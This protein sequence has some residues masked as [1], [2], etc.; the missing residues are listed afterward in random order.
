MPRS[1]ILL[2]EDDVT[3]A[4]VVCRYLEHDGHDVDHV[5]DGP[6]ALNRALSSSPDLVVLD[7][8]MPGMDG[9]E[10]CR[11][12]RRSVTTP[13]ILLTALGA[14]SERVAGLEV[15]AD[16]YVTKPFSPRELSLRVQAVLRR[17]H[18]LA[19]TRQ[20]G[21]LH[22]GDLTLDLGAR[23]AILG[24]GE[25]LLTSRE[26]DLL[27]FF[28]TN[29]NQVFSRKDLLASVWGWTVGDESTVTV[30]V[31]RLRGKLEDDAA[32]PR[33]VLTVWGSGYRYRPA[34]PT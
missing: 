3:I 28:L 21:V 13:V 16:D 1:K 22:D 25:L 32:V 31:R 10:V 5:A 12:M 11:R 8:M 33:R 18:G 15:G 6:T 30:H 23:Q 9:L 2:A 19:G 26:F 4:D 29:P 7:I 24:N 27:A 20:V 14:E 17:S 34:D